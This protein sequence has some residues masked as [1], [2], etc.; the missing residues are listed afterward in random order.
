MAICVTWPAA[1]P[2]W[3]VPETPDAWANCVTVGLPD[4]SYRL[5]VTPVVALPIVAPSAKPVTVK[6]M[7]GTG[8]P[9]GLVLAL[10]RFPV[11]SN[12]RVPV[13]N[14]AVGAVVKSE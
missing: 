10:G 12:V 4:L 14:G 7:G 6:V 9:G 13:A 11:A 8:V 1:A 2:S 3:V 5:K